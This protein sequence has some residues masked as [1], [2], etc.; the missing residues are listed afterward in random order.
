MTVGENIKNIRK[1]KGFTQKK[2]SELC[3]IAEPTIRKYESGDLN[4]KIETIEKIASALGVSIFRI[5]EDLSGESERVII[6][7]R[8]SIVEVNDPKSAYSKYE[9]RAEDP[10][11]FQMGL[12]IMQNAGVIVPEAL[13]ITK[14]TKAFCQL[15]DIGQIKAVERV[16]ELAKIPDYQRKD[17]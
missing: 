15:N 7:G 13:P 12:E 16:E 14:L 5:K 11:A 2:L 6:P 17:L 10:A 1:E 9:I 3:G 8:L 4:P